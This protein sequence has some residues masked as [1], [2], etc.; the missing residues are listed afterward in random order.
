M[1]CRIRIQD[2]G[3]SA[4]VVPLKMTASLIALKDG[5]GHASI[6]VT[7]RIYA[8]TVQLL[9]IEKRSAR[10]NDGGWLSVQ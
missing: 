4:A 9:L 1:L 7:K 2:H 10:V 5:L 3:L 8:Q 6:K